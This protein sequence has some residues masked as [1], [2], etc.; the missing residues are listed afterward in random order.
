MLL[1]IAIRPNSTFADPAGEAGD[2]SRCQSRA[3]GRHD[4]IWIGG[5]DATDEFAGLG[6]SNL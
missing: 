5:G 6:F 3:L 1:E 4:F 2:F